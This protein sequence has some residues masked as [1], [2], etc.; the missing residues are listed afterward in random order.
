MFDMATMLISNV[1]NFKVAGFYLQPPSFRTP[2]VEISQHR[3]PD[4]LDG[5]YENKKD[6]INDILDPKNG[7]AGGD[8]G[9][10]I[11]AEPPS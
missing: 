3:V 7:S 6:R 4:D 2:V 9:R 1:Q 5:V 11:E 8:N 10:E